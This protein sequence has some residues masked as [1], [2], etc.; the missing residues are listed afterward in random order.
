[1]SLTT[2]T[3]AGQ[4]LGILFQLSLSVCPI[5]ILFLSII[6]L[7]FSADCKEASIGI[8][9]I[10]IL[11]VIALYI[12]VVVIG[13]SVIAAIFRPYLCWLCRDTAVKDRKKKKGAGKDGGINGKDA[14]KPGARKK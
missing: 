9:S 10:G 3:S 6:L 7:F 11:T 8:V 14:G 12:I 1:M 5:L 2:K 13:T 4:T